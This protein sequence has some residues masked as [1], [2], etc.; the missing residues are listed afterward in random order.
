MPDGGTKER[1]EEE[2]RDLSEGSR[3]D[4]KYMSTDGDR[5][6]MMVLGRK[7]VMRVRRD[8]FYPNSQSLWLLYRY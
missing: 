3:L 5:R 8:L 4:R 1:A 7:Q 6:D 2:I